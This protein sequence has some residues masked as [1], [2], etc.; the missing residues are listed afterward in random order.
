VEGLTEVVVDWERG[1]VRA[2]YD[3]EKTGPEALVEA[4]NEKTSFEATLTR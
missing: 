3:P 1:R 2:T 4:V